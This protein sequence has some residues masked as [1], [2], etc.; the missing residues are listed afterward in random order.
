MQRFTHIINISPGDID[1]LGHVNNVVYLRWVQ[2]V[3]A[4]HWQSV[5]SDR[6]RTRYLWIVLR[7]EI[8]YR[9]PTF[10]SDMITGTTWVGSHHGARFER[11]VKLENQSGKV[12]AEAK[13]IWCMLD[14]T[15]MRPTRITDEVLA[16]L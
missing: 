4:A 7:H 14:G 5:S 13:T 11:F 9:N 3:A 12:V 1:E 2:E 10:L 6:L 15:S 8:D 16:L